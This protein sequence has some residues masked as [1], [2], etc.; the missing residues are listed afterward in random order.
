MIRKETW[1]V[2]GMTCSACSSRVE[3][4]VSGLQGMRS[5]SVN[6]LAGCMKLEYDD[7]LLQPQG[8]TACVTGL[9][10]GAVPPEGQGKKKRTSDGRL[11]NQRAEAAAMKRRLILSLLFL[12]PLMYVS[13]H[14]MLLEH[15]GIPVPGWFLDAVSGRENCVTYAFTQF[16][17]LIPIMVLNGKFYR[18][19]FRT[20]AKGSPNM[21]SLIAIGSGAAA[22]YGVFVLYRLSW[23]LGHGDA[24][25]LDRYAMDIYFESAGTILT[26]ITL[27]KWLETRSKARTGRALAG[28]MAL[29]PDTACVERGGAELSIPADEVITGDIVVIRPGDR[30]PVDGTVLEGTSSID[31]SVI[32]GESLPV[33]KSRGDAVTAAT[34]SRTGFLRSRAGRVGEDMAISRIIRLVEDAGATKAPIART[35]DR[36]AGVFV[37]AV[38]AVSV[39]AFVAWM[40]LGAGL[41]F[42]LSIAISVLV[43]SCP[44]ALGLATPVAIMVGTGRGAELGILFKSGEALERVHS[45]DTVV[46]DKTGTITEGHPRVTDAVVLSGSRDAMLAT[47]AGIEHGS[48]HPLAEAVCEFTSGEGITPAPAESFSLVPGRGV[49]ARIGG[50]ECHAGNEA[51]MDELGISTAPAASRMREL[52]DAGRTPLL[53]A[54]G[55]TLLGIIAVADTVKP[56]SAQAVRELRNLGIRTI[57]ITGDNRRTADALRREIELDGVFSQALPEDKEKLI[58]DMQAEGRRVAMIGDGINDAPALAR[59]DVGIAIGA[60]TDVAID[61]A[62]VVLIRSDLLDAVA[63]IRLGGAVIRNIRQNLFWAF[64]YNCI[65]IP[66]AAGVF[67][68]ILGWKLNPMFGAAAMSMSSVCVVTNALR[69]RLF[70]P[71]T[72]PAAPAP[73]VP[74][75]PQEAPADPPHAE[76]EAG[77]SEAAPASARHA[78]LHVQGM[79]CPHCTGRVTKALAEAGAEADVSL[80]AGT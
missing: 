77:L 15:F 32:T 12:I 34:I 46:L 44:C 26:L 74:S 9:G 13:M 17:L 65:G 63:A 59:A 10:Y 22:V 31:E 42:S 4:G 49:S 29:T 55:K 45:I 80:E 58:A 14:R 72:R 67:Y 70:S 41:E 25:L 1:G 57:M 66:L 38:I 23:A 40:M 27:G 7:D 69:L 35:A 19:G 20:L 21:D 3:K 79:M 5:A 50:D 16:L 37:P 53:I 39:L 68:S 24:A 8:I 54:R 64:F 73:A 11:E 60:G 36:I 75:S 76:E 6:L 28:L 51:M 47:A 30:I 56:T 2:T 71:G 62:D 78:V 48:G 43:I 52:A 18:V 33:E 61:S